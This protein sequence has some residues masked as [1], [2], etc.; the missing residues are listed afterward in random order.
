[1]EKIPSGQVFSRHACTTSMMAHGGM[2]YAREY[3]V[4]RLF[5]ESMIPVLAPVSEQMI[6]SFIGENVLGL[7]KS[8]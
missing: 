7:P 3:Q 8:Y 1:M 2:G 6:L 5:R 4:E